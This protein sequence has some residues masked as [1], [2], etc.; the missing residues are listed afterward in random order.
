MQQRFHSVLVASSQRTNYGSRIL[1]MALIAMTLS[2]CGGSSSSSDLPQQS[3][4]ILGG[5]ISGLTVDGLVLSDGDSAIQPAANATAFSFSHPI[6]VGTQYQL[7]IQRQPL[8]FVVHCSFAAGASS[9]TGTLAATTSVPITCTPA[10]VAVT[11]LAGS[12]APGSAD[13]IGAAASFT[14]PRRIAVDS[15]GNLYVVEDH[16]VRKITPDGAVIT[17]AG[18]ANP[19]SSDDTGVLASFNYPN[20]IAVDGNGNVYVAD[21][22]N[23]E[24]RKVTA[25]GVVSTLAG[26]TTAGSANGVAVAASF[27]NP[28][29]LAVASDGSVY[30]AD[31]QNNLIRKITTAGLVTTLAGTTT[32]GYA[33]GSGASAAFNSPNGIAV[34]SDGNV[35]V[36]DGQNHAIR[37]ITAAGVVSTLAGSTTPGSADGMGSAAGF[38]QPS[39]L[40]LD[41]DN[42]VYVADYF[43]YEIRKITPAG[44]VSTLAGSTS[45]GHADGVGSAASFLDPLGVAVDSTG[46]VYVSDSGNNQIRK[47]KSF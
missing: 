27:F 10:Q 13:G 38:N 5:T 18:S 26:S 6:D 12:I 21:S 11:T 2:A 15:N 3:T 46:N 34:D 16:K 37:K 24:I 32:A 25:A 23:N 28:L 42:N 31:T 29:A 43:N 41:S 39:G 1:S 33:D 22:G 19:G 35:Y 4:A 7:A 9:I 20:G 36:S 8:G 47:L 40:A 44:V 45:A 17:L 14:Y 30:V